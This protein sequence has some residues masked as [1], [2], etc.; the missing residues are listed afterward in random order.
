D[1]RDPEPGG[2]RARRDGQR[3]RARG[4][5][6][7]REA[8]RRDRGGEDDQVRDRPEEALAV[9]GAEVALDADASERR[10][11]LRTR[12]VPVD[13]QQH[14]QKHDAADGGNQL[15]SPDPAQIHCSLLPSES[16]VGPHP[17][18]TG[19]STQRLSFR[20]RGVEEPTA[21]AQTR[22]AACMRAALTV[23]CKSIAIVI[24]PTPPGTGVI[25]RARRAAP[26]KSTSP[27]KP[28]S[29][30]LM[31]TSITVAPSFTMSPVTNSGLPT[32]A[33]STSARRATAGR[34]R[35]REWQIVTVE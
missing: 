34:S 32:A 26:S 13:E 24:G 1:R 14:D 28:A 7:D 6:Q 19:G 11:D 22:S 16:A 2:Q 31:P 10:A 12:A 30:R 3:D 8:D 17:P 18:T 25:S 27:T 35:V 5:R 9:P 29:V 33:T 20:S 4:R 21:A 23:F 15:S